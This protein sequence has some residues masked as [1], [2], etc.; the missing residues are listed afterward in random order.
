[1]DKQTK[2]DVINYGE[3]IH[4]GRG[5]ET[6]SLVVLTKPLLKRIKEDFKNGDIKPDANATYSYEMSG[7]PFKCVI[8]LDTEKVLRIMEQ[9]AKG[10]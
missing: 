10:V 7:L 8:E 2:V 9:R 3:E 5:E 1:M 4:K 6:N